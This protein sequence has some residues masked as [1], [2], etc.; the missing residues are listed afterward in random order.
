MAPQISPAGSVDII[1][2]RTGDVVSQY[3]QS[4]D[5]VVNLT[6]TSIVRI[7]ASPQSVNYYQREG[8]DLIVHMNDGTTVRYQRF[9]VL[10]ENG[11]H[12][13]LIFEDNLGT[14]HAVFPF[15]DAAAPATA[16]AIVPALSEASV[17]SLVGAGGISALA[18]LG[19]VAAIGGIVGI[20]AA[21]GGGGS[22][23]SR[24]EA[25]DNGVLPPIDGTPPDDGSTTPPD[26][27]STTPPDDG[28]TTPPDDGGTTP[29]DD[30]GTTPPDDGGTTPPNDGGTTPPD[31]GGTTPPDDGGTTPPDDGGTTPPDDGEEP[32]P[33]VSTLL[34]DPLTG[35]NI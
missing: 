12:S 14:H 26:D 24:Q 2:Q 19:G 15:A 10:D 28:S 4:A 5:R 18:V 25:E 16:E 30:G 6:Q 33:P 23:S 20:A 17:D 32:T 3:A 29:P 34:I 11:L 22:G 31:D 9:F 1:N 35:D 13:E 21:A 8:N 7:N 27:G